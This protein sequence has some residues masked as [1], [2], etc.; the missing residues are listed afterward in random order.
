M[1]VSSFSKTP[2]PDY[3]I[4]QKPNIKSSE[5]FTFGYRRTKGNQDSLINKT[6]TTKTVGPGR[7]VPEACANPSQKKDYPKWTLPKAGRNVGSDRRTSKHQ[8]YDTRS[9]VGKQYLSKNKTGGSAHF[10]TSSRSKFPSKI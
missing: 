1:P 5:K 10:G 9:S 4:G 2:G 8:T 6:S 7:Y 3:N